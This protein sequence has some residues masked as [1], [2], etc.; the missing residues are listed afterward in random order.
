[1]RAVRSSVART[2]IRGGVFYSLWDRISISD[3]LVAPSAIAAAMDTSATPGRPAGTS[4]AGPQIPGQPGPVVGQPQQRRAR[5]P[6][7]PVAVRSDLQAV[8]PPRILHGEER[9]R[10]QRSRNGCGDLQSPRTRALFAP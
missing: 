2:A 10:S 6:G 8:I 7:Q 1:M 9:S 3:M 5:V 4:A